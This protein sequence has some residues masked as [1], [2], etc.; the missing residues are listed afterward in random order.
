MNRNG[1]VFMFTTLDT[2]HSERSELNALAL[3]K[4]SDSE[5][6]KRERGEKRRSERVRQ[7]NRYNFRAKRMKKRNFVEEKWR[8][9]I[10]R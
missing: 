4:A 2:F 8:C 1:L 5:K 3:K 6:N 9:E 7:T 10:K